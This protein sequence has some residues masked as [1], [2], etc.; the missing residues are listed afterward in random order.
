MVKCRFCQG[1]L[2]NLFRS[3]I[4][5]NNKKHYGDTIGLCKKCLCGITLMTQ[6]K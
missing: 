6:E 1:E 4:K 2:T 5:I 3:E